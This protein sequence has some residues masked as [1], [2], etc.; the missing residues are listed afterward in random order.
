MFLLYISNHFKARSIEVTKLLFS[1]IY[2]DNVPHLSVIVQD[3]TF[4]QWFSDWKTKFLVFIKF[5]QPLIETFVR[6]GM[7]KILNTF[8]NSC[9]EYTLDSFTLKAN[10]KKYSSLN[11]S[12]TCVLLFHE[13][14][15]SE[16]RKILRQCKNV[17]VAPKG[18]TSL[19]Y[20]TVMY[21]SYT[22]V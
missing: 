4:E 11:G 19:L 8:N 17:R 20:I 7:N 6:F 2:F 1:I 15:T 10:S 21:Q 5:L 9:I 18:Q 13:L 12:S 14:L 22:T 3:K 16:Y